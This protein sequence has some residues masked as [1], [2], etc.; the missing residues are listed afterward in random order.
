MMSVNR[1]FSITIRDSPC[2]ALEIRNSETQSLGVASMSNPILANAIARR[3]AAAV[4]VRRWDDFIR[5][6]GELTGSSPK[7]QSAAPHRTA[8]PTASGGAL[9]TTAEAAIAVISEAGRPLPTPELRVA[10][11]AR[12]IEIGGKDPLATL[13][14]RL[15]RASEI[16]NIRQKGWWIREKADDAETEKAASSASVQP[17]TPVEPGEEVAHDN[18]VDEIFR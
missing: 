4:E 9:A 1:E 16:V 6:Y 15:S 13:S 8:R 10:L 12:G 17:R 18:T 5:M 2:L 11:E 14:A 7:M 3:D